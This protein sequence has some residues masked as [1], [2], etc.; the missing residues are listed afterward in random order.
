[1]GFMGFLTLLLIALK[2]LGYITWSWLWV[3]SPLIFELIVVIIML[4]IYWRITK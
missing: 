1:M 4:V 3:F 2:L